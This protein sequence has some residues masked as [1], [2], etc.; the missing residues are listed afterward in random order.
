MVVLSS[1][2]P[3]T[4]GVKLM[5]SNTGAFINA[6]DLGRGLLYIAESRVSWVSESSGQGFSLEYPHISLHAISKDP[7]A[8]QHECLY[9]MLDCQLEE[10]EERPGND[11]DS[12]AESETKMT[13]VRFVPE[14]RGLLEAMFQAMSVCQALHPDPNDSVSEEEDF[15]DADEE[16]EYCLANAEAEHEEGNGIEEDMETGQFEDADPEH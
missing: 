16:G 5:Q 14:D 8:F 9:L 3:P 1:F 2:P 7:T 12:D 4:E 15:D 6:K 11:S 13:E 10:P